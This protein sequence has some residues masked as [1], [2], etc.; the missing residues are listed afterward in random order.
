MPNTKRTEEASLSLKYKAL[1]NVFEFMLKYQNMIIKSHSSAKVI[2]LLLFII[3]RSYTSFAQVDP[4]SCID[5]NIRKGNTTDRTVAVWPFDN[6]F[7]DVDGNRAATSSSNVTLDS[8]AGN[9]KVGGTSLDFSGGNGIQGNRKQGKRHVQG[10]RNGGKRTVG[11]RRCLAL[12][13]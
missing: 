11:A 3:V 9:F 1:I 4:S 2:L 6:S 10:N 13:R 5:I 12:I 7:D 8:S